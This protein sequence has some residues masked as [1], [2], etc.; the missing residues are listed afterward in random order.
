ML[1]NDS[2]AYTDGKDVETK[3]LSL[4][5]EATNLSSQCNIAQSHYADW[6]IRYHLSAMRGNLLRPFDFS[7]LDVLEL[8]AG[9]GGISRIL[10]ETAGHLTIVEGTPERFQGI[11]ARL[12]DLNNWEGCICNIQNFNPQKKFDVVCLIGVWEYSELYIEDVNPF[13]FILQKIR[14]YLKED[15]VAIIAIE[16]RVGLKY[17]SG[18]SEDHSGRHFDGICGYAMSRSVR[19]FSFQEALSILEDSGFNFVQTYFPH[20]DYKMPKVL[21]SERMMQEYST[22]ASQ[23]LAST[24][25]EDYSNNHIKLFPEALAWEALAESKL[26]HEMANSFLFLASQDESSRIMTKLQRTFLQGNLA[27]G[28]AMDRKEPVQTF[29]R[30]DDDNLVVEKKDMHGS[31]VVRS[32]FYDGKL[33]ALIILRKMYF[34]G[35]DAAIGEIISFV[36]WIFLEFKDKNPDVLQSIAVDALPHNA[37][38]VENGY[39]LFDLEW[40]SPLPVQKTWYIY[41]IILVLEEYF[42]LFS[43]TNGTFSFKDFYEELCLKFSLPPNYEKDARNELYFDEHVSGA[44]ATVKPQTF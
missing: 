40:V 42:N 25:S 28:Y 12:R 38:A 24:Q 17:F 27:T 37:I 31:L 4:L 44:R 21:F 13:L 35:K 2:I 3:I 26:L 20:P 5:K 9:M 11:Q 29:F 15:G 34:E 33:L 39:R 1:K 43:C 14:N 16:N 6:A 32:P 22:H 41:R 8:G 36:N 10:A 18:A 19:T 23:I 7:G 30:L